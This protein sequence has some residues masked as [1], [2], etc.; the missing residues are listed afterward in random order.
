MDNDPLIKSDAAIT[1]VTQGTTSAASRVRVALSQKGNER[2][3]TVAIRVRV[4]DV[5]VL[6]ASS[7]AV[8]SAV[9]GKSLLGTTHTADLDMTFF[10]AAAVAATGVLTLAGVVVEGETITLGATSY[11]F[12]AG[13]LTAAD[14]VGFTEIDISATAAASQGTL[15]VDTQV[16]A[17]DTMRIGTTTYT[18]VANGTASVAGE[19][20]LGADEAGVKVNIVAAIN[21]TDGVNSAHPLVTAAAFAGDDC[22]LTAISGGVAGNA[23]ALIESFTAAATVFDAATM[24]TTTAGD[25]STAAEGVTAIAATLTGTVT[26]ADGAGDTVDVTA[27]TAGVAGNLASTETMANGSF[28]SSTLTGGLDADNGAIEFDLTDATA[29][30]VTVRIGH[31]DIGGIAADYNDTLDVTHAA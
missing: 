19:I 8:I 2:T 7:D 3:D 20:S 25:D 18:F 23:I 28:A 14:L 24:G 6:A 21:G 17:L 26:G 13:G 1:L 27:A 11:K 22:V 5:D 16:T 29:E 15:T 12:G 4:T 10:S 9:A 30:T 31:G